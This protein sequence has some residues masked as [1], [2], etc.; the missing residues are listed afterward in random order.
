MAIAIP[1]LVVAT[2]ASAAMAAASAVQQ[3][4]AQA[5]AAKFNA[6]VS[7]RNAVAARQQASADVEAFRQQTTLRE[8]SLLAGY[9]A[10][11]VAEEGSPLDVLGMSAANA[12][13]DELMI[14][15]KGE[16]AGMG[17]QDTG[18]LNRMQAE[19]AQEGG[20]Y[21]ASS[22]IL[23]GVS[24]GI[25]GYMMATRPPVASAST[26]TAISTGTAA[27]TGGSR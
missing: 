13:R 5:K 27:P 25:S 2:V 11:G 22:S 18:S 4:K 12:K 9:G 14:Q 1:L 20:Y 26:G 21:Q 16:L 8:G 17:Y 19:Q 23:T 10:S 6:A 15:Y 24:N 7:D 3:S